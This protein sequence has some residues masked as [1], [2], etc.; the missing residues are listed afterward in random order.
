MKKIF[1]ALSVAFCLYADT[2][3]GTDTLYSNG[4][5]RVIL[6]EMNGELN[7]EFNRIDGKRHLIGACQKDGQNLNCSETIDAE[8]LNPKEQKISIKMGENEIEILGKK[9]TKTRE[10]KVSRITDGNSVISKYDGKFG[11][12]EMAKEAKKF[13]DENKGRDVEVIEDKNIHQI[14]YISDNVISVAHLREYDEKGAAHPNHYLWYHLY[15]ADEKEIKFDEIISDKDGFLKLLNQELKAQY[16]DEFVN[17]DPD[18][19]EVDNFYIADENL[20]VA[21]NPPN[22]APVKI[23]EIA[24]DKLKLYLKDGA[25]VYFK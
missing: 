14:V 23:V 16:E 19:K 25:E 2:I 9:L 17:E 5:D 10:F 20:N 7:V 24:V 3:S 8:T 12:E 11:G 1:L 6:S 21:F 4:T 15:T 13:T 22:L 18:V